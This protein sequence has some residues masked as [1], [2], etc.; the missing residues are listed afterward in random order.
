MSFFFVKAQD[1]LAING[2]VSEKAQKKFPYKKLILPAG[3][4]AAGAVLKIPAIEN[5]LQKNSKHIFGENFKSRVDDYIQYAPVVMMFSGRLFGFQSIHNNK[6]IAVNT[7]ISS[8][9]VGSLTLVGKR[10]FSD[11]RP[12]LSARN[13]YPSG[14]AA[15]AFNLA[16][17]QFLE[18][19]NSNIWYASSGYLFAIATA[20]MRV[21]NNRHWSG[22]I[23]TG[24]GLGI[25]VAVVVN[26]WNPFSKL[27]FMEGANKK[28]GITGYPMIDKNEYGVGI[29]IDLK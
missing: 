19:K 27:N 17:L 20:V 4:M 22:D 18:Y 14:H 3:L 16:T 25:G 5:N 29:L 15:V 9:I 11:M 2:I 6:Q 13:S 26:Y 12:D 28:I 21:A 1:S 23:A 8:V 24:A 10:G 7:A